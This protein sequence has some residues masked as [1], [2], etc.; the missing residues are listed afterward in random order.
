[1]DEAWLKSLTAVYGPAGGIIGLV[2]WTLWKHFT[3]SEERRL[4][5]INEN[6][7]N[8]DARAKDWIDR[9]DKAKQRL[10]AEVDEMQGEIGALRRRVTYERELGYAWY[11]WGRSMRHEAVNARQVACMIPNH[12]PEWA[13][14]IPEAGE[15]ESMLPPI[16]RRS[17]D[18]PE[19]D[20]KEKRQ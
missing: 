10:E 2:I 14:P 7:L 3:G 13:K 8:F 20:F 6:Q 5:S 12:N 1:M 16:R 17:T 4:A 15:Y 19:A 9:I 18:P 11:L